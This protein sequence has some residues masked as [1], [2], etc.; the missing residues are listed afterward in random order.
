MIVFKTRA[1]KEADPSLVP[2]VAPLPPKEADVRK[3]APEHARYHSDKEKGEK[4]FANTSPM[5]DIVEA[6]KRRPEEGS[7][8]EGTVIEIEKNS[9]YI[10]LGPIGTGIIYGREFIN[11]R[12]TIKK[13]HVGDIV[14]AK[15][16]ET[17]NDDGYV[18]L[19]LK[20]A[21][22]ALIWEEAEEAIQKKTMFDLPVKEANKGGLILEWQG[23]KGFL[24]ASQLSA[25]HYPRV[26]NGNKEKIFS[27]LQKFIG[28][29]ISVFILS[30]DSKEENL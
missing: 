30:A 2:T 16:V 6:S 19:S 28:E 3:S 12:D 17:E 10:D 7:I 23:I 15:V 1:A 4:N 9:L 29:K 25:E 18:E 20:E 8:V 11:A 13:I 26:E 27:E 22:Q 24:P 5:V 14:A 21:R